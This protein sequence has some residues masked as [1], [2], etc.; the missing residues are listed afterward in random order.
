MQVD[1]QNYTIVQPKTIYM[2]SY[3]AVGYCWRK[4]KQLV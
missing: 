3:H 4:N 2:G 1:M